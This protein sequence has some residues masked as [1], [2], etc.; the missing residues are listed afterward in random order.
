MER[1]RA[2]GINIPIIPGIKP[3]HRLSQLNILPKVFRADLPEELVSAMQK[4]RDDEA[5]A[6]VGREWAIAQCRELMQHG[7]PSIHFYTINAVDSVCEIAKA[8]Y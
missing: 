3:M 5:A 7:V 4:C 6:V 8:I 1:A 2:M